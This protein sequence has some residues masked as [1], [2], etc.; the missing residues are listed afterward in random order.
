MLGVEWHGAAPL[1]STAAYGEKH[2]QRRRSCSKRSRLCWRPRSR[3][4]AK[5]IRFDGSNL[6]QCRRAIPDDQGRSLHS[7]FHRLSRAMLYPAP[8][9]IEAAREALDLLATLTRIEM[10]NQM[11]KRAAR[12]A[13]RQSVH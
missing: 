11:K 10:L 4:R 5:R 6:R 3:R 12:D 9:H 1:R 8:G 7:A 2:W 13:A